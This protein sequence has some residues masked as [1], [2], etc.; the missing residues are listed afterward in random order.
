MSA[1]PQ[2]S[3]LD[4][5]VVVYLTPWCPYCKMARRLLDARGIAYESI[6]VTGNNPARRWL[7][8]ASGQDTVPQVFVHG[9]SVG[10]YTELAAA[11]RSGELT[12]MLAAATS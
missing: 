4:A 1:F 11:D 5:P 7:R 6:D 3:E 12:R 9:Q 8:E 10:G 2:P